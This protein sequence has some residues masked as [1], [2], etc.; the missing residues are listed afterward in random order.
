MFGTCICNQWK[1]EKSHIWTNTGRLQI[2]KIMMPAVHLKHF[3]LQ[4]YKI[5]VLNFCCTGCAYT[6][7]LS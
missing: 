2:V 5:E 6:F 1:V 3:C 4:T 7:D